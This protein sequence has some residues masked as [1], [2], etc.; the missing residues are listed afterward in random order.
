MI[1]IKC[2]KCGA[3]KE[4]KPGRGRP[5]YFCGDPC[6]IKAHREERGSS[7]AATEYAAKKRVIDKQYA[8]ARRSSGS[9]QHLRTKAIADL[10]SMAWTVGNIA[11]LFH[12]SEQRIRKVMERR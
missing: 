9:V 7:K 4:V 2:I 11:K 10:M 1:K 12:V 8:E 3:E 6:R 5:R